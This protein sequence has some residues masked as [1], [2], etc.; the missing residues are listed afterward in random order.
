MT[1]RT[2]ELVKGGARPRTGN[3]YPFVTWPDTYVF[4][5]GKVERIWEG[6]Y[7]EVAELLVSGV[8]KDLKAAL[9][10]ETERVETGIDVGEVVNLGLGYATLD[11]VITEKDIGS[12]L[13]VSFAGWSESKSGQRFRQFAVLEVPSKD[14]RGEPD[15]VVTK[16]Q[17]KQLYLHAQA[18][19]GDDAAGELR[20]AIALVEKIKPE[21][22]KFANVMQSELPKIYEHLKNSA[23]VQDEPLPF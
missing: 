9:G 12:E 21:D 22:V 13:H 7:G 15:Q 5:E 4:I 11:G 1:N 23:L 19:Y 18:T 14:G 16:A 10:V 8:S 17:A 3:Q 2:D 6:K 20:S